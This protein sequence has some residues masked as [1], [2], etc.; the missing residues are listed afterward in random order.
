M[1]KQFAFKRIHLLVGKNQ[2]VLIIVRV[3]WTNLLRRDSV[4]LLSECY[5]CLFIDDWLDILSWKL[6]SYQ[7]RSFNF[8][9][10]FF[11]RL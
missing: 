5:R 7:C 9:I 10:A 8:R 1:Q 2:K 11:T 3:Q 4:K 6:L